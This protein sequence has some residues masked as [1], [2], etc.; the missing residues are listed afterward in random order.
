MV[1]MLVSTADLT[2]NL[3]NPKW[4]IFDCRHDLGDASKGR[5]AYETGHIAGAHFA[6]VDEDL[7]GEKNGR[8]GRHPLPQPEAFA[9]FL[10]EHGVTEDSHVVAY[11]DV[12]GQ[13]AA[14]LWWV[15]RWIGFD[16]VAL[17][18]GG[19]GK[20]NAEGRAVDQNLPEAK[21][22]AVIAKTNDGLLVKVDEVEANLES[23]A[24]V[25][26]DARAPERYRGEVEPL[27]RVAGHIPGALNH[28]FKQS[29]NEDLTMR[30]PDE[31]R[32]AFDALLGDR[33]PAEVIH[34]CGS[35]ITACVNLFAMEWAGLSGS[36]L[37]AGSWSEWSSDP[38]RPLATN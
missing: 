27:D 30:S 11:D 34:Q 13:Y 25:V 1:D 4:V 6:G 31:L 18:D 12:G 14:R 23:A 16:R 10:A 9:A 22:G 29:L 37:Y 21:V 15:A 17:L 3:L 7:S 32:A 38:A 24:R 8:N 26:I 2:E 33:P 28:V 19:W 35:G 20:W 36:K 5:V